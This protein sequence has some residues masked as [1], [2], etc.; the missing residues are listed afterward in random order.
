MSTPLNQTWNLD[1]FF[2]GGSSSPALLTYLD[3]LEKALA[4]LNEQ[5]TPLS[6]NADSWATFLAGVD[7][8][9]AKLGDA[10]AFIGCLNS[11]DVRDKQARVLLGRVHE[12]YAAA[13][14]L[15]TRM[16]A[17]IKEMPDQ[18]WKALLADPRL[19]PVAFVLEERR[20]GAADKMDTPRELLA[21][22]LAIDGYHALDTLYSTIV[23]R[24]T[25]PFE[26]QEMSVG[27]AF[28][29]FSDA[30]PAK[31]QELFTKWEDAWGKEAD[32]CAH[33]L[34][35]LGGFRLNLYKHRG[36]ESV[37]KEPLQINRMSRATLDA[38]WAAVESSKEQMALF[39]NRRAK[40]MGKERLCWADLYAP[41]NSATR[42]VSY[43]EAAAFIEEQ[44]RKFSPRMADFAAG[45][46]AD[47]WIEVEDRPHK[48]PGGYMTAFPESKVSRIF[49]TY[50]G[51][52]GGVSTLAHELGHAYHSQVMYDL[53]VL[54][55]EYSMN[56]AETAST[57]AE[58]IVS[59]AAIKAAK[60]KEEKIALLNTRLSDATQYL[61]NIHARFIFETRFYDRRAKGLLSVAELNGLMEEAQKEAY[62]NSLSTY[63]PLFWASKG[64]FYG[65]S[66]PF[67]NFP[68]TFGYLFSAAVYARALAEGPS[69]E[70]KYVEL[71]RDTGR[72]K[73]EELAAKHLGADMTSP[74][75]WKSG[76]AVA[77]GDLEEFLAL[78]AD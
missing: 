56:V 42:K 57:F 32:L 4:A 55:Q 48:E 26:G 59:S 65:T 64:H 22:D 8:A 60:S 7:Q 14:S 70:Q 67:Y 73:V 20:Q 54:L 72:M 66:V 6:A 18:A 33:A 11:Q 68:Y 17:R 9:L 76:L 69:F 31:R 2:E 39:L 47:R 16:D 44:F 52:P 78:T 15:F 51:D 45:A 58:L 13:R 25:I 50:S 29:R 40:L 23:G 41:V 28:N 74:E 34:N 12:S 43:D 61:M 46:F 38:M 30:D 77:Y 3:S 10:G 5:A 53:P 24:I 49:M 62:R 19:E 71:L 36:W 1:V 37:L 21:N 27:Q 63:H 75:F 35:H